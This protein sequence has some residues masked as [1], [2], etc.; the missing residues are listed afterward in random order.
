M[1]E[2]TP[3]L[4]TNCNFTKAVWN[5]IAPKFGLP[6]YGIMGALGGPL[7]WMNFLL[8]SGSKK[9]KRKKVGILFT[10]WWLIWKERNRRIFEFK[11]TSA[12]GL[13]VLILEAVWVHHLAWES[14]S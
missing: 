2:T 9:E 4:L 7:E 8:K 13:A 5:I 14:G 6:H 1:E 10:F 12:H 3:H 11:E